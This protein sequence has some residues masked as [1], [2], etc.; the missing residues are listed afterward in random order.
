MRRIN[1]INALF[2]KIRQRILAATY[3]QPERWWFLSEIAFFIA[4]TPSSVQRELKSLATS[5]I[6]RTKR[7]GNR[8][9]FRAETDSPV[10]EPLQKLIEQT[11][12][13]P[14]GL[15]T[16]LEPLAEKIDFA[17]IYGSVAR[18]EE[19]TLSDVDLMVIGEVGLSDLSRV[20]RPL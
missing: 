1:P 6:L 5:G 7:D 4:T 20:L 9:Y 19:H 13:I 10:F 3:G 18:Q 17:L 16:A 11:L 14:E 2:P 12:G 8:L 15:K